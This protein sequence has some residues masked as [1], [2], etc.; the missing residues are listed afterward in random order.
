MSPKAKPHTAPKKPVT[1][2]TM[3]ESEANVM[4]PPAAKPTTISHFSVKATDPFTVAYYPDS[5]QDYANVAIRVN[6]T[7][8]REEFDV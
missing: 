4:P 6:G 8:K 1:K 5:T 7:M 2:K 3:G